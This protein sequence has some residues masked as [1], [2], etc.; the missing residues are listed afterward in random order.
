[1]RVELTG[2]EECGETLPVTEGM[3]NSVC[4]KRLSLQVHN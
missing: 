4:S 2:P 1:M 3:L